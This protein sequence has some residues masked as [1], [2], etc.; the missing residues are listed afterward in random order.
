MKEMIVT[1]DDSVIKLRHLR[2]TVSDVAQA[3]DS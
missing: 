3:S 1:G 2:A